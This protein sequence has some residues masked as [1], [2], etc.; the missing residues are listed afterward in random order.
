MNSWQYASGLVI[1]YICLTIIGVALIV[2][3]LIAYGMVRDALRE[4]R[5]R[6]RPPS[7]HLPTLRPPQQSID[8]IE[9]EVWPDKPTEWFGH[10]QCWRCRG[11]W[12]PDKPSDL[13]GWVQMRNDRT[14]Q[15]G[16]LP[17]KET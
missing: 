2:T 5:Y 11:E 1:A 4:W 15:I 13:T 6:R 14:G 16:W 3:V 12:R 8:R 7:P 17:A 10:Q 9:H